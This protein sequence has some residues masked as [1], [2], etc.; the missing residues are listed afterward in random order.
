MGEA[1]EPS[2]Y[3]IAAHRGFA[4]A[5]VAGL[6]PRY[7]EDDF[8]LA[9]LTLLVPSS[10]AARTISE[11]FVRHSGET[12]LLMPRMVTVGDLD[13]DE[14]LGSLLDPLGA[15]DIPPAVE[16]T[17]RWLEI[18]KLIEIENAE[19]GKPPL[20]GAA[21]LR[22]ARDVARAMDRLLVEDVP[23]DDL[24]SDRILDMLGNLSGH[25]QDSLRLFSRVQ[26]R[27]RVRL[28]EL[29]RVDAAKRR[30][31][32]FERAAKRWRAEPPAHPI[33]A[34][35]VTSA[36]PALARMLRVIAGMPNGAVLLP[37]LDLSM[38]DEAWEE[39]GRAGAAPEPGGQVF[40]KQD[41]LTHPQYHLKLLLERMGFARAEVRQWHRKGESAAPPSRTHA[42]SSLFLPP[43]ASQ[44]WIGIAPEKRRL[45]GVRL[46]TS[47]NPEE[48]AQAIALLVRE[49][50][51]EP[52]KR[53]AVVTADRA[54]ARRIVQHLSRWNIVADDTAGRPLSLTPAGR[55]IGL[56]ADLT[57]HGLEPARFIGALAHPLIHSENRDARADWL[58]SLRK[59][60][61]EL[62]GP[63][64]APGFAPLREIAA[65]AKISD[66]FEGVEQTL[67]P[68]LTLSAEI[69]LAEALDTL[70]SVA[71]ALAGEAV[72]ARE[73][74]RALSAMVE[75]LRL[76]SRSLGTQVAPADLAKVLRDCMDEIA[77]RP[78]YGGHPRVSIY[79]LLESRMARADLVI[80]GGL[81]EGSWPQSPGPDPLLAPGVLRAL[82]V[83]GAEFRI[84]L[85]AHDLAGALGA[86]EVVLSRAQRD[87]EGP[88]LASRFWLRVEALLGDDLAD[89]HRETDIPA[90]LPWLDR[91]P[92]E[93]IEPYPRPH[94]RPSAQ[95]RMVKISA[96]ALDRLLGD[97]YQFYAREILGL[98]RLDPLAADPFG[99]P[100]LRGTLVHDILDQWHKTRRDTPDL[101]IASFAE[102]QMREKQ[103][104]PLFWG[105]WRPRLVAALE[106]FERWVDEAAREGREVIATEP[107][108]EMIYEGVAVGGRADR[109]DRMPDGTLGI[110]DYKTGGPPTAAQVEAGYALQLGVLGLIARY[111]KFAA[112]DGEVSGEAT[113]FE[114]WSLAKKGGEFGF[115]EVP[116]K[117][118][119][120]NTGLLTEKFLPEHER[121]LREAI[122][123]YITGDEPF[124]AKENPDYPGY[125]D[126]DQ[127]MRLDEWIVQLAQRKGEGMP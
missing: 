93:K 89:K 41:V 60:D 14:A 64:P 81:N 86:P 37:D 28:D 21:R 96:T 12:G 82:G 72:W 126:Y 52:E 105:L 16:P 18:A 102:A 44:S 106:R 10:R 90:I 115:V 50:I 100:A 30:N 27:W 19:A 87:S 101:A 127:L 108:G 78:P 98:R 71:E 80:C 117:V 20:T 24:W 88:A 17:Q 119:R 73:D 69:S 39:L 125:S 53:V 85:S 92:P 111:G 63:W 29:G 122:G 56:L 110:V 103:V 47:A 57:T 13:L 124:T 91:E 59:F 95:Q 36:A 94:P 45:S 32:L 38:S 65:E 66:W 2:V 25:W 97:P 40:G 35:G 74:G 116:M 46:M 8:G 83:P 6:V 75:D 84:G 5:L 26:V 51:D 48:E 33:V 61:R 55:L 114:Y 113:C 11:A 42:I 34:A 3:S 109:I 118:G 77:V 58:R 104:H 4:D 49:A 76:H 43:K 121:F 54:L 120:K 67:R 70:V 22:L 107:W 15:S 31:M 68:L 7:A 62:R 1:R 112:D 99:D 123:S 23:P 9:R 79:G